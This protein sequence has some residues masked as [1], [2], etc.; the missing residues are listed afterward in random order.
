MTSK[1]KKI[2]PWNASGASQFPRFPK[3]FAALKA[4]EKGCAFFGSFEAFLRQTPWL[5][6]Q[7]LQIRKSWFGDML[8]EGHD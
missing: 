4:T 7:T 1:K 3:A 6:I 8:V 5:A 2:R